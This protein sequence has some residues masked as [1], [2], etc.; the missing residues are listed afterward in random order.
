MVQGSGSHR[1]LVAEIGRILGGRL[2]VLRISALPLGKV[3]LL[4]LSAQVV[5]DDEAH[6]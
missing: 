1:L 5:E 4:R 2:E 3:T 6:L